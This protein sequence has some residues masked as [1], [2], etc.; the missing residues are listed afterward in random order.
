SL[1]L[2]LLFLSFFKQYSWSIVLPLREWKGERVYDLEAETSSRHG[3]THCSRQI[4][5]LTDFS[6]GV[7]SHSILFFHRCSV[8]SITVITPIVKKDAFLSDPRLSSPPA[9]QHCFPRVCCPSCPGL[10]HEP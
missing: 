9:S 5:S 2:F 10:P 4:S 6:S 8:Q 1:L 3:L 7:S